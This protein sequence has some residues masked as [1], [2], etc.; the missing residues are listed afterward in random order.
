MFDNFFNALFGPLMALSAP[1]N[2][3]LLS[4]ILTVFITLVYKYVTDQE[5]MKSLKEEM[6]SIQKG[7]K[8]FKD[9]PKKVMEMQKTA[10][11]RNMKYMM[12]SF[13]PMII[14]FL[15]LILVFT[16]LRKYYTALGNPDVLFGL[17][18]IWAYIIFSLVFGIFLRKL[19][20]VH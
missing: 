16:W 6:K 11:E 8:E 1:Y 7:M 18:W 14:T 9:D 10:M 2:L 5:A 17:T 13:K 12:N 4:L 15:P 20:K 19:F 3:A